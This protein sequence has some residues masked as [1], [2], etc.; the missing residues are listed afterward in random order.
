MDKAQQQSKARSRATFEQANIG[1]VHLA[2]DGRILTANPG[3]CAITG[4][5]EEELQQMT[6]RDLTHPD[7]FPKEEELRAQLIAGVIP[8]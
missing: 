5:A 2:E 1:I 7:D 3:A 6:L 4:Y 8:D